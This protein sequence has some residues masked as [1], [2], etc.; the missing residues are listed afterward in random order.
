MARANSIADLF[1]AVVSRMVTPVD[2]DRAITHRGAVR[3]TGKGGGGRHLGDA[4]AQPMVISLNPVRAKA[5][6]IGADAVAILV[7]PLAEPDM[8][9]TDGPDKV[10]GIAGYVEVGLFFCLHRNQWKQAVRQTHRRRGMRR[11]V[12]EPFLRR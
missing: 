5:C 4:R 6:S 3:R 2:K 10:I 7:S 1:E 11:D 9:D 8:V 12:D